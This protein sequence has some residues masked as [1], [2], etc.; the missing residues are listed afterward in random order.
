M[1]ATDNYQQLCAP[2]FRDT[3]HFPHRD[4][5]ADS[6][7][8]AEGNRLAQKIRFVMPRSSTAA[9]FHNRIC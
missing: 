1:R 3:D 6:G 8:P 9:T 5:A 2:S 7:T 4:A